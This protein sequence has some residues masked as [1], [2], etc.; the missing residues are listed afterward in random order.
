MR[1]KVDICEWN[2]T[3]IYADWC[4]GNFVAVDI[5]CKAGFEVVAMTLFA[6]EWEFGFIKIQLVFVH[7]F[8]D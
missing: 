4:W 6:G 3:K 7:L 5:F 8:L 2:M 1:D